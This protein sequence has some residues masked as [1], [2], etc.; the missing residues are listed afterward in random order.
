MKWS[1]L[2][3][4]F[5]SLL[6]CSPTIRPGTS[7][8][9]ATAHIASIR[10]LADQAKP[11]SVQ[12]AL[13]FHSNEAQTAIVKADQDIISL[14]KEVSDRTTALIKEHQENKW[15]G[16]RTRQIWF[17]LKLFGTIGLIGAV[18][19]ADRLPKGCLWWGI[20]TSVG[21]IL[22][23]PARLVRLFTKPKLGE[24]NGS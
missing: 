15:V 13:I 11:K 7:A 24:S 5:L 19:V 12:E 20:S 2:T 9:S 23:I 14:M 6:S 3:F 16:W 21:F 10:W 17:W 18:I 8:S 1:L 4:C 22:S